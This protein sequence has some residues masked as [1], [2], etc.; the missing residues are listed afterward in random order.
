MICLDTMILI[1]GLQRKAAPDYQHLVD[2][3]QRYLRYLDEENETVIIPSPVVAEYL[4]GFDATGRTKQIAGLQ[5]LFFIPSFDLAS[6][7]LTAELIE[8]ADVDKLRKNSEESR[9]A[10][11]VDVQI[12][13]IAIIHGATQIVTH[14]I[15]DFKTVVSGRIQ[16]IEVPNITQPRKLFDN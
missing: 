12:A 11:K 14:N 5:K 7:A 15:K 6:A 3:T 8:N 1:W 4:Q 2:R 16:V 9:S 13:A 10:L